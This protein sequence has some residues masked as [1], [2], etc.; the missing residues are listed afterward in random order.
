MTVHSEKTKWDKNISFNG[1]GFQTGF[2]TFPQLAN[3]PFPDPDIL[4]AGVTWLKQKLDLL[5][6]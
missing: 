4:C 2:C 3:H 6:K 5:L 1:G